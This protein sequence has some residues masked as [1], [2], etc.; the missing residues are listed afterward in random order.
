MN[1]IQGFIISV[2]NVIMQYQIDTSN[3]SL[4]HFNDERF[5]GEFSFYSPVE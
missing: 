4:M 1:A 5:E 2:N 3:S